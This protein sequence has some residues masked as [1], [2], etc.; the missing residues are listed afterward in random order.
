MKTITLT[1]PSHWACYLINDDA[2]G[3]DDED[4]RACDLFFR[5]QFGKRGAICVDAEDIGF[6]AWHDARA[7]A[8]AA[9]CSEF[10]FII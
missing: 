1:A 3:L 6:V 2:S 8:L 5:S 4:I 7:Y 9:D 10:T